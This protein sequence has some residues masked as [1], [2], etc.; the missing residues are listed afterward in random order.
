MMEPR[1]RSL[2]AH[3]ISAHDSLFQDARRRAERRAEYEGWVPEEATFQPTL[4]SR[5]WAPNSSGRH[6]R[7]DSIDGARSAILPGGDPFERLYA[8][9]RRK[10]VRACIES[11]HSAPHVTQ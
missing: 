8:H 6:A 4:H 5:S 2:R 9:H 3:S 1:L 11:A 7:D 10:A